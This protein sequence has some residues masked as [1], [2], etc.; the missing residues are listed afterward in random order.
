MRKQDL[1]RKIAKELAGMGFAVAEASGIRSCVDIIAQNKNTKLVIKAVRNI[2]AVSAEEAEML[3]RVASFIGATSVIVGT[4][5]QNGILKKGVSYFRFA[6]RCVN[7]AEVDS[8]ADASVSYVASKAVG[9]KVLLNGT[10]LR[11]LRQLSGLS[12]GELAQLAGVSASTIYKRE[13]GYAFV[14]LG[15]ARKLEAIFGE[16]L[17]LASEVEQ[18]RSDVARKNIGKSSVVAIEL[19]N[20]PFGMLAK[21]NNYYAV[22][23]ESDARTM[24]K[25]ALFFKSLQESLENSI[26][27]FVSSSKKNV[28][29]VKAI[30]RKQLES[31]RSESELLDLVD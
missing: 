2:D 30:T 21:Q 27:F 18:A 20:A 16:K 11:Q 15:T 29:G 9:V 19:D 13:K 7:A 17:A 24:A 23:Y 5:S 12:L 25:K 14:S 28:E 3:K 10:R 1:T 4:N 8:I 22:G 31:V 26:P 6:I